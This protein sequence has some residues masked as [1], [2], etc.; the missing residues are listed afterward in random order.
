[1]TLDDNG[2]VAESGS[3][4]ALFLKLPSVPMVVIGA[5]V[6]L[7]GT[8]VGI[9]TSRFKKGDVTRS[10]QHVFGRTEKSAPLPDLAVCDLCGTKN[11]ADAETCSF[12]GKHEFTIMAQ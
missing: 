10:E 8:A 3:L 11:A 6:A 7:A 5:V 9:I 4:F 12:C 1:M 2:Y